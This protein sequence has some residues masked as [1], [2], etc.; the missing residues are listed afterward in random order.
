MEL[1]QFIIK[2]LEDQS[3]EVV[4]YVPGGAAFHLI[5]AISKSSKLRLVP[6]FHE[7]AAIIAAEA[8]YK[9]CGK[10][11]IVLVTAGPG[12]SN[13]STG[14]LSCYV[15]R[16]PVI[17]LSG[18][19]QSKYLKQK[20]LR[21]YGPQAISASMLY[22]NY[23][24]VLEVEA[25]TQA[26]EL[27]NFISTSFC[28]PFGPL[29]IQIPLDLQKNNLHIK[30]LREHNQKSK[31]SD[32][33][34]GQKFKKYISEKLKSSKRPVLL[35]GGGARSIKGKKTVSS[36]SKENKIPILLSWTAKD[37]IAFDD[38]NFCGLPGYFCNRAANTALHYSDLII[39]IGSRLDPLQTGYQGES[40][41][42]GKEVVVVDIDEL[43][44]AKHTIPSAAKFKFDASEAIQ[45]ID[46]YLTGLDV[47]FLEWTELCRAFF[48]ETIDEMIVNDTKPLV[49]PY[50]LVSKLSLLKND[51]Y[52]AGS[53]GGSAEL[54]FLNLRVALNQ[55]FLNSPGLGSMGFAI[56]SVIGALEANKN[57]KIICVVGDGGFQ[58][59]IQELA[60]IS[61]YQSRKVMILILNNDGYDSMRRSLTKYFGNADHVDSETGLV[62]PDLK[63]L[64]LAYSLGYEMLED[65]TTLENELS[66]IWDAI[67]TPTLVNVLIRKSVE[68]FP[69]LT[70][71]MNKDGSIESGNLIDCAPENFNLMESFC[72]RFDLID[73]G[74]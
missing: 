10:I 16:I 17:I 28:H 29:L 33:A 14:L 36:F 24:D 39:A 22:E 20:E 21:I 3:C 11:G 62:F 37:L 68:S 55:T 71:K 66:R 41:Y 65:N 67:D 18:Q 27:K 31:G 4:F 43:E 52:I 59:N 69:K 34:V 56:P 42:K 8:Y 72:R 15:D 60:S 26:E 58:F 51:I 35:L 19:A 6:T 25:G 46:S 40:F 54:S 12:L 5:D 48:V 73:N 53:S 32:K 61:R 1:N 45:C 70:P 57:G 9:S 49:D 7:Q 23:C 47:P 74:S 63:S 13:I 38:E 50:N 64:A 2:E 44:L 30:S